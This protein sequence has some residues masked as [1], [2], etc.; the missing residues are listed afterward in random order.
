MHALE[1]LCLGGWH[2]MGCS[3]WSY[4]RSHDDR[5]LYERNWKLS[6]PINGTQLCGNV[7]FDHRQKIGLGYNSVDFNCAT[8][9]GLLRTKVW[10]SPH[11]DV[12]FSFRIGSISWSPIDHGSR[13][14]FTRHL[15]QKGFKRRASYL[16]SSTYFVHFGQFQQQS[17]EQISR[18]IQLSDR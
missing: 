17:T 3:R 10:L 18:I 5:T 6:A 1:L 7:K 2:A 4:R 14:H 11:T 15:V 12:Y 9:I 13:S 8:C 16:H